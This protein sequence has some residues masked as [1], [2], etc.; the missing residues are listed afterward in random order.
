MSAYEEAKAQSQS[1][2]FT[3]SVTS[4]KLYPLDTYDQFWKKCESYGITVSAKELEVGSNKGVPHYHGIIE[5]PKGFYRKKLMIRGMHLRLEE[6]YNKKGW[7]K[8]INKTHDIKE[9]PQPED[10]LI[11]DVHPA[12]PPPFKS[13]QNSPKIRL[14]KRLV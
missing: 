11:E 12:L 9:L 1:W 4:G 2:A 13:P 3:I 6:L 14:Y 10:D 5:I 8:Y 7:M